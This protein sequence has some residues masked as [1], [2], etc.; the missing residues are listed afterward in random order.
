MF[1][2]QASG[3]ADKM[4]VQT[5]VGRDMTW[6]KQETCERRTIQ[7]YIQ[8]QAEM[9]TGRWQQVKKP[10]REAPVIIVIAT[11]LWR[12]QYQTPEG[13]I[14]NP[15]LKWGLLTYSTGFDFDYTR[16]IDTQHR[17]IELVA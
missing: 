13:L 14:I 6:R 16:C 17:E 2:E 5:S 15:H 4:G 11:R 9:T 10:P 7:K 12:N 8:E 1:Y 3:R